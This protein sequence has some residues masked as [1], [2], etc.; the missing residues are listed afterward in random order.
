MTRIYYDDTNLEA[1]KIITDYEN[2]KYLINLLYDSLQHLFKLSNDEIHHEKIKNTLNQVLNEDDLDFVC[3]MTKFFLI[4]HSI[5]NR[6]PV[7]ADQKIKLFMCLKYWT[8]KFF[9]NSFKDYIKQHK[10]FSLTP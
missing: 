5:G 8:K 1:V 6:F 7:M 3:G 9:I 10:Y 4:F 2:Y